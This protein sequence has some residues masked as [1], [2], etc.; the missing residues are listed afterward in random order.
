MARKGNCGERTK[1]IGADP[2]INKGS[3]WLEIK[4]SSRC[5]VFC[6]IRPA[7]AQNDKRKSSLTY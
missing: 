3:C 5:P 7:K 4:K 1:S 6:K 2:L